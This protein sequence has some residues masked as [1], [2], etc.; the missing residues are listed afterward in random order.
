MK[1]FKFGGEKVSKDVC[2]KIPRSPGVNIDRKVNTI[3]DYLVKVTKEIFN[4]T[5]S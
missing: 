4:Y 1:I 2:T 5:Q 3:T